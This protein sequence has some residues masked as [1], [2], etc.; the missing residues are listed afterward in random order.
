MLTDYYTTKLLKLLDDQLIIYDYNE[1]VIGGVTHNILHVK[2]NNEVHECIICHSK[3]I[4]IKDYRERTI[5]HH[6]I[7]GINCI[8][9]YHQRRC[10]CKDCGKVFPEQNKFVSP[11]QQISNLVVAGVLK[12]CKEQVSFRTVAKRLNIS[13]TTVID[14]FLKHVS[15][16]RLPLPETIG[17][18][19]FRGTT[20]ISKYCFIMVNPLNGDIIEILKSRRQDVVE[21]FIKRIPKEERYGV[22]YIIMDLW[23]PYKTIF[24]FW[25]PKAKIIADKF[26]Y[27]R[28]ISD[29]FNSIR[30]RLMNSI[31]NGLETTKDYEI[32]QKK[33]T[34]YYYLKKYWKILMAFEDKL[35]NKKF[36]S[37]KLRKSILTYDVLDRCLNLDDKL[38]EAYHLRSKILRIF[39]NST[40]ENID[41]NMN[42]WIKEVDDS[43]IREYDSVVNT[44][45]KW[46]QE[47]INSFII[48]PVTGKRMTNGAVEGTNNFCKVI[49]RISYG[50]KNFELLRAK[51]LY[52]S[53]GSRP[54]TGGNDNEKQA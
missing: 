37:Y 36:F 34:D 4:V 3:N 15:V 27:T 23:E 43:F 33:E 41:A 1:E 44:Y 12:E 20:G 32:R 31:K 11:R 6:S 26:H 16:N 14:V 13:S 18:D 5:R 25:F 49:K 7:L 9:K 28:L 50:Y 24:R 10:L 29:K 48:N 2:R 42:A 19:E 40:F 17:I 30:I 21:D 54:I 47:I 38:E 22:K 8:I 53:K 46:K 52:S 45:L 39:E 35:E 51:I